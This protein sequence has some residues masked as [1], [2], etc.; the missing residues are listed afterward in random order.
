MTNEKDEN[1]NL[2][3]NDKR[4]TGFGRALRSLSLDELPEL[5]NIL[6]GD[7]S[8]IGPRPLL[9]E[10]LPLYSDEQKKRHNIV[11][12]LTGLA[13]VKGRNAISWE[14]KFQYDLEYL[15]NVSLHFDIY[16]FLMTVKS[17][18]CR[19]NINETGKVSMSKFSGN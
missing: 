16:I 1:G 11:P 3:P 5:F 19:E 6:K 4:V 2:L 7:M 10:Y 9:I 8:F 12:G 18:L 15:E 14:Q 17:V 13:Q